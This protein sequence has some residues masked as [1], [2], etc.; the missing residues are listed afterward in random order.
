MGKKSK[1]S[2]IRESRKATILGTLAGWIMRMWCAT[3]RYEV[4]DRSG[5]NGA[6][7]RI[8]MLWHN[9][10]FA[11]PYIWSRTLGRQRDCVVLTSA[12]HDGAML[13]RAM[14]VFGLG[15]VRG[16][17]SRRGVAALIGLKRTLEGG[18]DVC[19]TP[20]GPRGPRYEVQ[21]G[22]V[23]VA[24]FSGARILPMH[25][26]FSAAWRVGTWDRLVIP[27]PF[28]TVHVTYG[29]TLAVP[30]GLDET[31]FEAARQAIQDALR[32]GADD[33]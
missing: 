17:S 24:E 1:D 30:R 18:L 31:A 16:S 13:A 14:G 20:D 32:A 33:L 21:P 7:P 2:T 11:L 5:H 19:I 4:D 6:E 8:L 28:S 26:R 25:A 22:V 15:A 27:R 23:K 9:R 3:L 10:I 29:E 12:S